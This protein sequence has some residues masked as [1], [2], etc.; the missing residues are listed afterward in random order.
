[1]LEINAPYLAMNPFHKEMKRDT[2][3]EDIKV[4]NLSGEDI[5]LQNITKQSKRTV[6]FTM[7][8]T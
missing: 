1:V 4:Q 3:N 6:L 5:T 8:Q 7:S 2:I